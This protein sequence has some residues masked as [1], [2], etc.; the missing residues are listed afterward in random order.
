M[1]GTLSQSQRFMSHVNYLQ[2]N[3]SQEFE[4]RQFIDIQEEDDN[5]YASLALHS[6]RL[7]NKTLFVDVEVN[8]QRTAT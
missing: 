7:F 8:N 1:F 2:N 3:I 6:S 4:Q 5:V